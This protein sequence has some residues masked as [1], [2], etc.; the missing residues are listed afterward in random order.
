M[1]VNELVK[2]INE[3][4]TNKSKKLLEFEAFA[5]NVDGIKGVAI[6]TNKDVVILEKFNNVVIKNEY[7]KIKDEIHHV[8]LLG[9][10]DLFLNEKYGLLC[11][12]FLDLKKRDIIVSNPILW[13]NEWKELLG[14]TNSKK[15]IYDIVGEMKVLLELQKRGEKPFWNSTEV[16]TYDISSEKAVYEVKSSQ[17]KTHETIVVHNQFQLEDD[18]VKKDLFIT[19]C[20][21]EKNSA[22]VSINS[23]V[24]ELVASEYDREN[25]ENYLSSKGY[26]VGKQERNECYVINE[27]RLY[28][29]DEKFPKITK[30]SFINSKIP[31]GI[32]NYQYTVSLDNLEYIRLV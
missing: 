8:V 15:M 29:V 5:I 30:D 13:F 17:S 2:I 11:R 22:G 19:F 10:K 25:I 24:E 12:D 16:G 27:I 14:T 28:K 7:I 9:T 32:I 3:V 6:E 20:K 18:L 26:Y 21:V 31:E 1:E 4:K 23:L